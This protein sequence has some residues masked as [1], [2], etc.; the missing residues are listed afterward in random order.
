MRRDAALLAAAEAGG[1]PI[2]RLFAFSPPGITLGTSQDP[3]V[4]L[5]LARCAAHGIAV[6]VRPTGGR[7]IFHADEWTYALASPLGDPT[8][9]GSARVTAERIGRWLAASLVTLGIP[10]TLAAGTPTASEERRPGA[11]GPAPPC[12]ATTS[13]HEVLV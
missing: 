12:F 11:S 5:D 9:G 4:E 13:R 8:W 2:L 10:A 7:A 6:A 1:A 3:A